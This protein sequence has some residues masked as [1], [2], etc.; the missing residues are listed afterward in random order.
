MTA[1]NG[2]VFNRVEQVLFDQTDNPGSGVLDGESE[3]LGDLSTDRV[4][5][6]FKIEIKGAACGRS[7]PPAAENQL[8]IRD[9]R[10]SAA[11]PIASRTRIGPGAFRPNVKHPGAVDPGDSAPPAPTV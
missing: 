11:P 3:G 5:G 9:G 8:G 7:G 4:T 6:R 1:L 10:S 2:D